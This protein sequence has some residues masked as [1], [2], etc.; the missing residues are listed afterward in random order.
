M[1]ELETAIWI[2]RIL[3][4]YV[5]LGLL[6]SP[7]LIFLAGGRIDGGLPR[8]GLAFRLMILPGFVLLWPLLVAR[9]WRG[10]GTPPTERTAHRT[11]TIDEEAR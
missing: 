8:S 7:W 5:A 3:E 1:F 9:G 6:V 4:T 2:S 10:T 11:P